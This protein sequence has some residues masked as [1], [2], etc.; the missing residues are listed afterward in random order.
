[1]SIGMSGF[2]STL[3]KSPN[4]ISHFP[5]ESSSN[6]LNEKVTFSYLETE[7]SDRGPRRK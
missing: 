4:G 7:N 5:L 6:W 2:K 1:M 3:K